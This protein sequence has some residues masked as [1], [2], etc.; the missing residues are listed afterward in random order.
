MSE[1]NLSEK[2]NELFT[3]YK[4]SQISSKVFD[5]NLVDLFLEIEKQDKEFIGLLKEEMYNS[6][7]TDSDILK[8]HFEKIINKLTGEDLK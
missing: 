6:G 5:I 3:K 7:A 4:D 8:H 2:R 1:L